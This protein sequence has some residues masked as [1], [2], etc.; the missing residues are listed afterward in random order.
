MTGTKEPSRVWLAQNLTEDGCC[1][2]KR[3]IVRKKRKW[4][5]TRRT[6]KNHQEDERGGRV[7]QRNKV[8]VW[9]QCHQARGKCFKRLFFSPFT[10]ETEKK[11]QAHERVTVKK[12]Q[13]RWAFTHVFITWLNTG[14]SNSWM[15]LQDD[16]LCG[17]MTSLNYNQSK[18]KCFY[19]P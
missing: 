9:W 13:S 4:N 1:R 12:H 3:K 14:P 18:T 11:Q 7:G 2:W 5:Q 16:G 15:L 10:F 19:S 6:E 8:E 17:S